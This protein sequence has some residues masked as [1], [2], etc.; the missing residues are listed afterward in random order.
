MLW[1]LGIF[2][3]VRS[4]KMFAKMGLAGK[5]YFGFGAVLLVQLCLGGFLYRKLQSVD[6]F[7]KIITGDCLPGVASI[8]KLESMAK[9]NFE[10]LS[11]H[12]LAQDPAAKDAVEAEMAKRS[13][14]IDGILKAYEAT[15]T[16]TEDRAMFSAIAPVREAY[17]KSYHKDFLPLSRARKVPE[18][19]RELTTEIRPAFDKYME[20]VNKLVVWNSA[21]GEEAGAD[22][23]GAVSSSVKGLLSGLAIAAALSAA[24][25]LFLSRS[26]GAALRNVIASLESGSGQISSASGQVSQSSQ[27]LAEGASE[28]ASSLEETSASLEE[29][30]SMTRQ[31]SDNARQA[32]TMAEEAR[33]SAETGREAMGRMGVA[34]GK[35]KDSSDQTARIIKTIDEIAFQTNLLALNAA[36]EAA[37]AGDAGKGFAVVAEEVRNLARRS[38]EAAKS[39]SALIEESQKNAEQGVTASAEVAAIQDRIVESVRKLA[40]LIGEVS[41]ASDEQS[42]GIGQISTAV[43]QMDKVTQS[44]AAS[45]EESAS[46]SEEL[47]AQAKELG[48]MVLA[49]VSV[50][51]GGTSAGPAA[52]VPAQRVDAP[53][54]PIPTPASRS[55]LLRPKPEISGAR[56][57]SA[58]EERNGHAVGA[59]AASGSRRAES[60]LPLTDDEIKDF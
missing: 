23:K 5:L 42:K 25:G 47:Y 20:T 59:M 7:E 26:I 3:I 45:A 44:N 58:K 36:V 2:T 38:A 34:I 46:A 37:R 15:I 39:T 43:E 1:A 56:V 14:E 4:W 16:V 60:V 9:S 12:L 28:Q 18:A 8:G 49:L 51:N 22:I 57:P 35:I 52:P 54:K 21:H 27:S 50:V 13:A 41:A 29:L 11:A 40:Q 30:S 19:A 53:R 24:I 17:L 31:N 32:T 33:G 55:R 10:S 48:D 6:G